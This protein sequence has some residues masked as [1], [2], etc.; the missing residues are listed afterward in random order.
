MYNAAAGVSSANTH[1]PHGPGGGLD[2]AATSD[3][4]NGWVGLTDACE[5]RRSRGNGGRGAL[6]GYCSHI[7]R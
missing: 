7:R 1:L 3:N 5:G 2:S 6:A 4:V